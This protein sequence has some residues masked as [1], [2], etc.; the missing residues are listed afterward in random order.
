MV[1]SGAPS[2]IGCAGV[3]GWCLAATVGCA[4]IRCRRAFNAQREALRVAC[5]ELRGPLAAVGLGVRLD[6]RVGVSSPARARAIE[7][8][9]ERAALALDDLASLWAGGA[10]PEGRASRPA[11]SGWVPGETVPYAATGSSAAVSSAVV[12]SAVVSSGP[13]AA[14]LVA[15]GA[16]LADSLEAWRPAAG[17]RDLRL[18]LPAGFEPMACGNRVRLAQATGNLIANAV[19]HGDGSIVVRARVSGA[20]VRIEVAD[21]GDGLPAT[22]AELLRR[23]RGLGLRRRDQERGRGLAISAAIATAHGGRLFSAPTGRGALVVLELPLARLGTQ[24]PAVRD[25]DA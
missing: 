1:I 15:L 10:R 11:R 12:S 14:E 20:H 18:E 2:L 25:A 21:G 5:H 9:L 6:A 16:L 19:E 22:V 13:A 8:Q 3:A 7:L 23:G 24:E 17:G 4:W